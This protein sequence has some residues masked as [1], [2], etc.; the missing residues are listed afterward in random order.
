MQKL[1][2]SLALATFKQ[3]LAVEMDRGVMVLTQENF[4]EEVKN[5]ENL[6]I[7]FYAPGW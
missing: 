6:L 2:I 1:C 7:E 3:A 4:D 5:Y